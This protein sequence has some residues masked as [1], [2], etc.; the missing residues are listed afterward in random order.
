MYKNYFTGDE[1]MDYFVS[2]KTEKKDLNITI[3]PKLYK[4][5]TEN[6]NMP[7]I[8]NK[9][10]INNSEKTILTNPENNLYLFVQMDV[11]TPNSAVRYEFK[12]AFSGE[13]LGENGLYLHSAPYVIA[14]KEQTHVPF[15][16]WASD[17]TLTALELDRACLR[18]GTNN[19]IS[20]DNIF[21]VLLGLAGISA[22][23]YNPA[24]DFLAA[25]TTAR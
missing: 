2:F 13:S 12:N 10:V 16:I 4:Y 17:E 21:H 3:V 18:A 7:E 20:H 22:P 25:C 15:L 9:I 1:I 11:C 6:R 8:P 14:P 23:E 19:A 5:D 24:L